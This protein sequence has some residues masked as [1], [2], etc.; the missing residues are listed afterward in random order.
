MTSTIVSS[1]CFFQYILQGHPTNLFL[2][3]SVPQKNLAGWQNSRCFDKV[4]DVRYRK[5]SFFCLLAAHFAAG[6]ETNATNFIFLAGKF[7]VCLAGKKEQIIF[8]QQY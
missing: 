6:W 3:L 7:L 4:A 2:T 5:L 8:S 1:F